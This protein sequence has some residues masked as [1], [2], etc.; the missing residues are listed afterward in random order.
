M[1]APFEIIAAPFT[2]YYAPPGTAFPLVNAAPAVDW[3][4]IGTSGDETYDPEGVTVTHSQEV[5]KVRPLGSTVPI[6]AFRTEE[7]LM[8]AFTLWDVS[9]EFYRLS[10]NSNAI[11]TVAAGAGAPGTKTV[12][13]YRGEQVATMALLLRAE[14][15]PYGDGM[16]MQYEVPYCFMSGSPEPVYRKGEP[17]GFAL[18]FSALR[19]PEAASKATSFGRLVLQHQAPLP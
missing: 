6:K 15:S 3:I 17:A 4:K 9:A 10:L 8:I 11:T 5:N 19:D 16:N 7:E 2:A 12:Q 13:F 14:V 1:P 18:E